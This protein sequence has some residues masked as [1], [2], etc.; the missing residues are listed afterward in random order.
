MSVAQ[1]IDTLCFNKSGAMSSEFS[2]LYNALFANADDY[3]AVVR[4]IAA[5]RY[6]MTYSEIADVSGISGSKLTKILT[7]L[8]RCDFVMKFKYYGKKSQDTIIR[9]ADF[10]TLFYLRYRAKQRCLRRAVVV[11]PLQFPQCRGMAMA[12]I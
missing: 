9:L 12:D 1:N 4:I 11:E 5:R 6:G 8:E 3:I 2:E 7:N 10:Y